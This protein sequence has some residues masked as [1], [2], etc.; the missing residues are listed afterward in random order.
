VLGTATFLL[1]PL[2]PCPC[3]IKGVGFNCELG[4]STL[5][6]LLERRGVLYEHSSLLSRPLTSRGTN[7]QLTSASLKG[8]EGLSGKLFR[9]TLAFSLK[10]EGVLLR[11]YLSAHEASNV[12]ETNSWLTSTSLKGEEDLS[13]ELLTDLGFARGRWGFNWRTINWPRLRSRAR[14]I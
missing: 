14:R 2:V 11:T 5:A 12:R 3:C 13:E 8:A 9:F 1:A 7:S 10:R 6:F 4:R